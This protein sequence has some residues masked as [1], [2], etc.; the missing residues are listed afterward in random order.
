MG[1]RYTHEDHPVEVA[2]YGKAVL[3]TVAERCERSTTRS[4]G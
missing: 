2:R 4:P 3:E 1:I